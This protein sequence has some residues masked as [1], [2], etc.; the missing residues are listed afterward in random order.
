[1]LIKMTIPGRI[2]CAPCS[3]GSVAIIVGSNRVDERKVQ[4]HL[5]SRLAALPPAYGTHLQRSL[6]DGFLHYAIEPIAASHR[7]THYRYYSAEHRSVSAVHH[8][9]E[10][11]LLLATPCSCCGRIFFA[12]DYFE[13]DL[14]KETPAFAC[15]LAQRIASG[16]MLR[17]YLRDDPTD[18]VTAVIALCDLCLDSLIKQAGAIPVVRRLVQRPRRIDAG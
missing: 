6:S 17:R 12:F 15:H 7:D 18:I 11:A 2:K 10:H 14:A 4:A 1:M 16:K 8:T 5:E 9:G 13:L 3:R